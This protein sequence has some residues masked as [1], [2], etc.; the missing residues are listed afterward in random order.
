VSVNGSV[1]VFFC[2]DRS[3][4]SL[5]GRGPNA[6][7]EPIVRW[8]VEAASLVFLL[9]VF[10]INQ[11]GQL[12]EL[13]SSDS[14][15]PS[16]PS[17]LAKTLNS[18]T[19]PSSYLKISA[20]KSSAVKAEGPSADGDLREGGSCASIFLSTTTN[21]TPGLYRLLVSALPV[22]GSLVNLVSRPSPARRSSH[23]ASKIRAPPAPAKLHKHRASPEHHH[24]SSAHSRSTFNRSHCQS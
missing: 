18:S 6:Y 15:M 9:E 20:S 1:G 24:P 2:Y 7:L 22:S 14:E 11:A 16:L 19:W 3:L 8:A 21:S 13:F 5:G 10:L 4:V 23:S 17:V 12:F